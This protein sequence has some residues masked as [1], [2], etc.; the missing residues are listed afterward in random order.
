MLLYFHVGLCEFLF[1]P[2]D[3]WKKRGS[4]CL[5]PVPKVSHQGGDGGAKT[6]TQVS[7]CK[8][9]QSKMVKQ[10]TPA[11][12]QTSKWTR[13]TDW[14]LENYNVS[15]PGEKSGSKKKS[16]PGARKCLLLNWKGKQ[17]NPKTYTGIHIH[18]HTQLNNFFQ[19]F[20]VC[21]CFF[22]SNSLFLLMWL[23][24]TQAIYTPRTQWQNP[25]SLFPLCL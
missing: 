2:L 25:C 21:V 10:P 9:S 20:C 8:P 13:T 22:F 24:L 7:A 15:S 4:W 16:M 5:I 12:G 14:R 19:K 1:S 6:D 17:A 23:P 11:P 3:R 18:T